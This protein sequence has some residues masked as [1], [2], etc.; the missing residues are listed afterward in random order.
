M[1]GET[2]VYTH[3]SGK[4]LRGMQ[5][6]FV[7]RDI[8]ISPNVSADGYTVLTKPKR[9]SAKWPSKRRDRVAA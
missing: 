2:R 6:L 1:M 4:A 3:V 8:Y 9:E 7:N 5:R